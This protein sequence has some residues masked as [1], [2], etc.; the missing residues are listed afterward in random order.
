MEYTVTIRKEHC[1]GTVF[2][3]CHY[4]PLARSIREQLPFLK[5]YAVGAYTVHIKGSGSWWFNAEFPNGWNR[6]TMQKLSSGKIESHSV[7]F[8][9]PNHLEE[10]SEANVIEASKI[11]NQEME[12]I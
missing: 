10:L 12:V 1:I 4:C 6:S 9:S 11:V 2:S 7:T 3:D 5:L 8:T